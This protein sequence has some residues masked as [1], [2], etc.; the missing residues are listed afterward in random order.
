MAGPFAV[1]RRGLAKVVNTR[2]DELA[3]A[4]VVIFLTDEVIFGKVAPAAV[5]D[6]VA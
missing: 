5:L 4:P 2:P 3:H 6:V 1:I